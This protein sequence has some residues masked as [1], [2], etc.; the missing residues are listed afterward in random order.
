MTLSQNA[1]ARRC[2]CRNLIIVAAG[3]LLP[4]PVAAKHHKD[5]PVAE[6]QHG[7]RSLSCAEIRSQMSR[8]EDTARTGKLEDPSKPKS[9]SIFERVGRVGG[10]VIGGSLFKTAISVVPFGGLAKN[11]SL[12]NSGE[13]EAIRLSAKSRHDR[14]L[15]L[16]DHKSCD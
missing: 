1:R 13:K 3:L 16:Y 11:I 10:A 5:L 2:A 15:A 4:L 9:H 6:I 8:M 14:L 12:P 7:D